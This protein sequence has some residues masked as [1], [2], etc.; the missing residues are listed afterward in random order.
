MEY[1][2]RMP[3]TEPLSPPALHILLALGTDTKHGYAIMQGIATRSEGAIRLLPGTLYSTLKKLLA[4]GYVEP[5]ASPRQANSEDGRRRYY[6]VTKRGR[7]AAQAE[8]RR[9]ALLVRLGQV[10]LT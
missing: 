6:R 9:L 3:P 1:S 7:A 8:T 10:F 4:D 5:C 2:Y